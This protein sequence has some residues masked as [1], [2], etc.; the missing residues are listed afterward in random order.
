[1]LIWRGFALS[2]RGFGDPTPF[3]LLGLPPQPGTWHRAR[4]G[5]RR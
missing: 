1:M 3:H 4:E 2:T 5:D